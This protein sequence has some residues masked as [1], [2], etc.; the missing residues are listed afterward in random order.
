MDHSPKP[1]TGKFLSLGI[2][3]TAIILAIIALV[4]ALLAWT[5]DTPPQQSQDQQQKAQSHLQQLTNTVMANQTKIADNHTKITDSEAQ[6]TTLMHHMNNNTQ[7][8]VLS[9]VTYLIHLANLQLTLNHNAASAGH[10]LTLAKAKVT[11]LDDSALLGLNQALANDIVSLSK[12]PKV[13][14]PMI[15]AKI[16]SLNVDIQAAS[17]PPSAADLTESLSQQTKPTKTPPPSDAKWYQRAWHKIS[18]VKSLVIIRKREKAA[19]PLMLPRQE[20][21]LKANIQTKLLAAEIAAMQHNNTLY[22]QHLKT[23]ADWIT[24]YF[25]NGNRK[26]AILQQVKALQTIDVNPKLPTISNSLSAITQTLSRQNT[27]P[28]T[29]PK[30]PTPRDTPKVTHTSRASTLEHSTT[31]IAL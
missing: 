15:I 19:Y 10:L 29:P 18:D 2:S 7:Q 4:I 12:V 23:V 1:T 20:I 22:Q 26:T 11:A 28:S 17:I 30:T 13:D 6:I 31:G 5:Q 9:Q 3:M 21:N 27:T 8:S 14:L 24:A 25:H 16:D